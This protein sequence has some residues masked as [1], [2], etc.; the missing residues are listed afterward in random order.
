MS[1]DGFFAMYISVLVQVTYVGVVG[2]DVVVGLQLEFYPLIATVEIKGEVEFGEMVD[3]M[4]RGL[5]DG[6]VDDR[7]M[8]DGTGSLR[9]G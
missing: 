7:D 1:C 5:D 6:M 3:E 8:F 2:Q 4:R 9:S